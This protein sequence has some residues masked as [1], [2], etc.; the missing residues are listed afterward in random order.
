MSGTAQ[1][2]VSPSTGP[3]GWRGSPASE[4]V[5]DHRLSSWELTGVCSPCPECPPSDTSGSLLGAEHWQRGG[6]QQDQRAL[7][8]LTPPFSQLYLFLSLPV[9]AQQKEVK[10][11]SFFSSL[12]NIAMYIRI[13]TFLSSSNSACWKFAGQDECLVAR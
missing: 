7:L 3:P 1:E 11:C 10:V 6:L 4:T 2:Q 8:K 5:S 9:Q 13:H 12:G